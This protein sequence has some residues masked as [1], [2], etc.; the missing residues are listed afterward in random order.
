MADLTGCGGQIYV[1][2]VLS[3]NKIGVRQSRAEPVRRPRLTRPGIYPCM[4]LASVVRR[5]FLQF[6]GFHLWPEVAKKFSCPF[7]AGRLTD[8]KQILIPEKSPQGDA[9]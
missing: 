1:M 3:S 4:C 2:G 6:G 9:S 5:R 7:G 8:A